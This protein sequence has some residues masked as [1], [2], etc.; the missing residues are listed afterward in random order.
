MIALSVVIVL[1]VILLP[2]SWL[3]V[4]GMFRRQECFDLIGIPAN[5]PNFGLTLASLSDSHLSSGTPIHFYAD[6]DTIQNARLE[7]IAQ[8]KHSIQFE[9]FKMSPGKRADDF[10]SVLEQQ[11]KKG[12]HIQLLADSHGAK[13]LS[14]HYWSRLENAG[15]EVRFFN[16]FSW[17]SP[18]DYLGRNHRKLLIIDQ[19][20][21]LI[22]GAGISD[23]WDGDENTEPWY[24][25]EVHWQG[26]GLGWLTGL[27]WQHWLSA[28]GRVD[29]R[30]HRPQLSNSS[31]TEILITSGE[32]PTPMN[33][34]IRSLFQT[35]ALSA[36]ERLWIASPYLLPDQTTCQMLASIQRR[37]IDVRVL[38]MGP[39]N[40]KSYVYYTAREH[41][42]SLLKNGI[43]LHEY[44]PSMMHAKVILVDH[45]WVC[46]GS[47]NLDPRSFFHNDEL[48][49]CT[50][51]KSL[52]EQIET[53]FHQGFAQSQ[54]IKLE[55]WKNR[56]W[57]QRIV[58]QMFNIGYWQL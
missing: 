22:G 58:G 16:P 17:R 44:Q 53:F 48:N 55:T 56:P 1:T 34:P 19:N 18:I 52:V 37:G 29:L 38:T 6:I 54:L 5:S 46:M 23:L 51:N 25:F 30:E 42:A 4:R 41:Y 14:N 21:A 50:P 49:I 36:T 20:T 3:Y 8:A 43:K 11:A 39:C 27:F 7:A 24:D 2:L 13:E 45:S 33:S 15:V 10:A 28:G 9:T 47:A 32:D 40:D 35:C 57:K 12:V 26:D 31:H